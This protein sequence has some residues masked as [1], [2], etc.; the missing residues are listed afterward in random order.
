VP[1]HIQQALW[2]P[3]FAGMTGSFSRELLKYVRISA[4]MQRQSPTAADFAAMSNGEV[5]EK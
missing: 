5:Y 3:A 2:I 4:V 1:R